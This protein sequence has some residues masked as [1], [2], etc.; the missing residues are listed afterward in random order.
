MPIREVVHSILLPGG[1]VSETAREGGNTPN[2]GIVGAALF[3][4]T[5]ALIG[6]AMVSF[7]AVSDP[8]AVETDRLW[9]SLSLGS[10]LVLLT[11]S[12]IASQ[13]GKK[14]IATWTVVLSFVALG[15]HFWL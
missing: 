15:L 7:E 2:R 1:Q 3:S 10:G 5:L 11:G 12:M 13:F 4:M 14:Q 6:T 8:S 9:R